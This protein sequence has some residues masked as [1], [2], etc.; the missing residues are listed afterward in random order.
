MNTNVSG[1]P[2]ILYNAETFPVKQL[3][4]VQL[5][6]AAYDYTVSDDKGKKVASQVVTDSHGKALLIFDANL[7]ATGYAVYSIKQSGKR[8]QAPQVDSKSRTLENS[9]YKLKVDDNGDVVSILDKRY[10]KEMIAPGKMLRLVVFDDCRSTSWPA[11]EI[12]KA[13]LDKE[14]VGIKDN[15]KIE[16]GRMVRCGRLSASPRPTVRAPYVSTYRSTRAIWPSV[17]TSATR[18]TGIA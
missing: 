18:W 7:P 10:N 3:A 11:W 17:S 8:R 12:L 9:I 1:T 4:E 16:C 5:P 6:N 13:T 15:V 14:P 2:Y